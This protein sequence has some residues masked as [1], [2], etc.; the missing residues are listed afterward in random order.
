M[1]APSVFLRQRREDEGMQQRRGCYVCVALSVASEGA[2]SA[3]AAGLYGEWRGQS[4]SSCCE[5]QRRFRKD[6]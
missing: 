2:L 1:E 4:E 3:A 5:K 6:Q